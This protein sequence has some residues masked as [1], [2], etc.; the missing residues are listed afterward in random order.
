QRALIRRIVY[1]PAGLNRKNGLVGIVVPGAADI[2]KEITDDLLVVLK[3]LV[4]PFPVID[5]IIQRRLQGLKL[6]V[7]DRGRDPVRY[8]GDI[9]LEFLGAEVGRQHAEQEKYQ[10][11]AFTHYNLFT[12]VSTISFATCCLVFFPKARSKPSFPN[13]VILLVSTPKP[14]PASL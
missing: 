6:L 4:G 11:I 3:S 2:D 1:R 9:G 8:D 10:K 13:I 12:I 14:A 7:I 5:E